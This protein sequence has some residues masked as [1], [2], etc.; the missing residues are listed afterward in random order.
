VAALAVTGCGTVGRSEEGTGDVRAGKELF[1]ENCG[2]CHV[3]ADAE[4]AG[5]IGPNL[6]DAFEQSRTD[7]LGQTTIQSVV[8]GQIAYPVVEPPT[9]VPGM[10][11]DIVEGED[12]EDVAAYV[13]SVAALPVRGQP[14]S[15]AAGGGTDTGGTE[16]GAAGEGQGEGEPDGAAVFADAGCG[17]CHALEAAGATG[18]VGPDLDASKP[19]RDL[20]VDRVTNGQGAMPSFGDSLSEEEIA[21][22]ADYVAS[23][24]GG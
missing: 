14:P 6:D 23:S 21:A 9:G 3:L 7:G 13:A 16:T 22:V 4:T 24:T 10:P 17:S 2:S 15:S 5:V 18:S 19:P 8:R 12:A 1:V 11:A 20:V